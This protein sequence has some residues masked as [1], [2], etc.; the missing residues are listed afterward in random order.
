MIKITYFTPTYNRKQLLGNLYESLKKQ[1][2]KEFIWLI[3]DDGSSDGTDKA[4][5]EWIKENQLTIKYIYKENGGKNTALDMAHEICETEYISCIDSDDYLSDDSTEVLYKYF[6]RTSEDEKLAGIVARRA[7]YDGTPFNESWSK[8]P[9]KICFYDLPKKYGYTQD[10]TLIFKTEVVKNYKFPKFEEERFVT[11]SVLYNQFLHDYDL[12]MIPECIYLA[13]YQ[14]NGYTSQGLNL[15]YK[16]PNGY[17]YSLKQEVYYAIKNKQN[18]KTIVAKSAVFHAWKKAL[19][20]KE[21]YKNDNK[22]G[23]LYNFLGWLFKYKFASEYS[24][25]YKNYIKDNQ[26]NDRQ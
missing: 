9:E 23:F 26:K 13:E 21:K 16:N 20:L 6:N 2:N 3:I 10:T 15:F 19:K 5:G 24:N 25:G 12:L 4:V 7:H 8:V 18:F 1:T 14:D 22:F 17:L 11:E